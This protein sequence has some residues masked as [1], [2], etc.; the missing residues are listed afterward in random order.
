MA[1]IRPAR[2]SRLHRDPAAS[3]AQCRRDWKRTHRSDRG[4]SFSVDPVVVKIPRYTPAGYTNGGVIILTGPTSS[5]VDIYRGPE[6]PGEYWERFS[7]TAAS[8]GSGEM[9]GVG[10]LVFGNRF[11]ILSVPTGYVSWY[12]SIGHGDLQQR[13]FS[14][15]RRNTSYAYNGRG[16]PERTR[17][18]RFKSLDRRL[19]LGLLSPSPIPQP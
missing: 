4:L 16:E 12:R 18:L 11:N 7:A 2:P 17:T 9:V 3:R 13:D 15:P 19:K 10:T 6:R 1:R 8:S 5:N 14:K